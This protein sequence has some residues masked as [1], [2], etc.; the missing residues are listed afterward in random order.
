M[1]Q[2]GPHSG[3]ALEDAAGD[4]LVTAPMHGQLLEVLVSKGDDVVKG[5]RLAILEAMKMQHEILAEIDGKV[6]DIHVEP[7][8][9]IALDT[10]ILEISS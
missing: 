3:E 1:P 10:L 5:Q 8:T 6:S 9:Q 2:V 4:G 7:N